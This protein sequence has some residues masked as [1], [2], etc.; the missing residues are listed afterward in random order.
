MDG[1]SSSFLPQNAVEQ[2]AFS[3]DAPGDARFAGAGCS[4]PDAQA[5][6]DQQM[7]VSDFD[8]WI[9]CHS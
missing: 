9:C 3:F 7:S 6:P 5:R 2:K 8:Q 4:F 1:L